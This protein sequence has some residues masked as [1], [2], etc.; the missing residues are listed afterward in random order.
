[1]KR[2]MSMTL[3]AATALS[4][5]VTPAPA[6]ADSDDLV[7][8][9]GGL[10]I[11]GATAKVIEDRRDRRRAKSARVQQEDYPR[12]IDGQLRNPSRAKGPKAGRGYKRHA[13]PNRCLRTLETSRRDRSVYGLRCLSRHYQHVSKLPEHCAIRVRT[14]RGIRTV[15]G[16]RCL[17]RDGWRVAGLH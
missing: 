4:I 1:M 7:K 2:L 9:L 11:L 15:F 3:A 16:A 6:A 8:V 13:L 5:A 14:H 17:K 12:I 10:L